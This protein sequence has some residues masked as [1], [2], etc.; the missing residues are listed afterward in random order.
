MPTTPCVRS[1]AKEFKEK[2]EEAAAINSK[3]FGVGDG[4][5]SADKREK[6]EEKKEEEKKSGDANAEEAPK[7]EAAEAKEEKAAPKAEGA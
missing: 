2:F 3:L 6:E 4:D 5:K 7:A 1:E